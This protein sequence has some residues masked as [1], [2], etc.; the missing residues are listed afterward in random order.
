MK[1][2]KFVF[3][4]TT[5][6]LLLSGCMTITANKS[7]IVT[8]QPGE[9]KIVVTGNAVTNCKDYVFFFR[10]TLNLEMHQVK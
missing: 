3:V 4:G 8:P 2:P 10:C 7:L 9:A 6:V 5:T 1:I